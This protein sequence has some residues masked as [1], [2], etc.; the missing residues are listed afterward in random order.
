MGKTYAYLRTSTD[1]QDLNNQKLEILEYARRH[2][3]KVDEFV[4][5]AISAQK[6]PKQRRID[7]L[8]AKIQTADIRVVSELSRL[9]RSTAEVI[10]LIGE[11]QPSRITLPTSSKKGLFG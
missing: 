3:L 9:G 4:E 10:G 7:E 11:L 6:T 2:D 8:M 5:I 1:K